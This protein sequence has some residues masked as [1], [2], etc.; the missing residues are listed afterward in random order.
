[1]DWKN[2]RKV[3]SFNV[4][5]FV[6]LVPDVEDRNGDVISEDEIRK[7]AY[8]FM[9][10]LSEKSVN[11]DHEPGTEISSATFVESCILLEDLSRGEVIVPKGSRLVGIRFDDTTYQKILDGEFI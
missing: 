6:A 4:V 2:I 8:D 1:M 7:T 5:I 10:N 3:E 9:T 11:I